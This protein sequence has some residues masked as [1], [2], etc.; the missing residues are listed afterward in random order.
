MNDRGWIKECIIHKNEE[1][2]TMR[3]TDNK[4]IFIRKEVI[5]SNKE[6]QNKEVITNIYNN[7]NNYYSSSSSLESFIDREE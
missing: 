1:T 3:I 6:L 7:K 5:T 2:L 4:S